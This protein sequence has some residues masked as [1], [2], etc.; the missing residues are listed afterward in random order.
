MAEVSLYT[1]YTISLPGTGK[2]EIGSATNPTTIALDS[3]SPD[4]YMNRVV[5]ADQ[6]EAT[7]LTV[8]AGEDLVT[9]FKVIRIYCSFDMNIILDGATAS[10]NSAIKVKGGTYWHLCS[11]DMQTYNAVL[12]TRADGGTAT[13]D[14]TSVI[15][16]NDSG[17]TGYC[18][19]W[20]A[21]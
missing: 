8:G 21:Y 15:A 7:L 2:I 3:T 17:G 10:N 16:G 20:A 18:Q 12:L 9:A 13:V 1:R 4:V 11:D 5:I 19:L 6:A 14:I